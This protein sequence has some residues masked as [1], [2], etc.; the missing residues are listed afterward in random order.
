MTLL[1]VDSSLACC[2][3]Q[4]LI[5]EL[6]RVLRK[7]CCSCAITRRDDVVI[8]ACLL[9]S[10]P[11]ENGVV[12]AGSRCHRVGEDLDD[13]I[14]AALGKVVNPDRLHVTKMESVVKTWGKGHNL[15]PRG[16]SDNGAFPVLTM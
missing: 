14:K 8:R 12:Y 11:Q 5:H 1:R 3:Q 2:G 10:C 7:R 6:I 9:S 15:I 13:M 16:R 4:P